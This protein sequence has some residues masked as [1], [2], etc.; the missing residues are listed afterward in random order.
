MAKLRLTVVFD[1][2]DYLRPLRDGRI[3]REGVDLNL[4]K[5][6]KNH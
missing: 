5:L 1:N 6:R 2:Y 4:I 3:Q